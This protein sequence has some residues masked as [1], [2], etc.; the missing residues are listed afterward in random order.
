MS[1]RPSVQG[2][3][4]SLLAASEDSRSVSLDQIGEALGTLAVTADEIDALITAL[5]GAGRHI[6]SPSG[7]QGV[8]RLQKVL[9][10]ARALKAELGRAPSTQEIASRSGLSL[11]A[12]G[13]ALAL[14]KVMQ[15]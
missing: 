14:A 11:E 3:L 13:H 15:R 5:E 8:E 10:A 2:V 12:V 4:S 7:A 6:E 1:F 9:V